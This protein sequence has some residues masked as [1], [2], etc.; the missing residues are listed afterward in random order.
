MKQT[1][2]PK[3]SPGQPAEQVL[4]KGAAGKRVLEE[5]EDLLSRC[6]PALNRT[7]RVMTK[8]ERAIV[9]GERIEQLARGAVPFVDLGV[10]TGIAA[11]DIAERELA[12][13]RLP[14]IVKRTLPNGTMEYWR[15][16]DMIIV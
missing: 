1:L 16:A 7:N 14:F 2:K 9:I 4:S 15:V 6:D 12:E 3:S 10:E 11:E 8:Y 5:T 13:K